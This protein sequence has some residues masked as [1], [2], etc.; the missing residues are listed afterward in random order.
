MTKHN[1]KL[2]SFKK[3]HT[4]E[5][6]Q[7]ESAKIIKKYEGRIPVIVTKDYKCKLDDMTRNKFL[8]PGDLTLGQFMYV[9]RKRIK[10]KETESIFM[11]VNDTVLA[12]TSHTMNTLYEHYKDEDGFLYLVYCNENV[13]G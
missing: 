10:L 5:A 9:I 3:K 8:A 13:F 11:F 4:L 1:D 7:T 12:P 2:N 6:R